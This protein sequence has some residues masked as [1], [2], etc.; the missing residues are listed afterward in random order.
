LEF[1]DEEEDHSEDRE[2]FET[3]F[4]EV[5]SKINRLLAPPISRTPSPAPS[6]ALNSSTRRSANSLEVKLPV[7]NIPTFRGEFSKWLHFRDT[8]RAL[9]IQNGKLSDV[10]RFHNLLSAKPE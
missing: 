4:Y 2:Q 7:I 6:S 10:Q 3:K 9:V 1:T 8:I 5:K